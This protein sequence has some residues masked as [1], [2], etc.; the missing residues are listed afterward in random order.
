MTSKER[1]ALKKALVALERQVT[2]KGTT[3]I[4]P[5]RTS[6]EEVGGDEDEQPLNEMMQAIASNRN[7]NL[8]G[9]MGR[10]RAAL[11]KLAETPDDFGMCEDCGDEIGHGRLTA[12][13]YA[14]LCV[15]CQGKRDGPRAGPTRKRLTDFI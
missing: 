6:D 10:V 14:E 2:K 13:P 11:K 7:K 3:R 5:N 9:V 8:E 4:S 12:M 1:A 15:N